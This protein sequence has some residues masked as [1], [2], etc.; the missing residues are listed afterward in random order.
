MDKMNKEKKIINL[1]MKKFRPI[2]ANAK[3]EGVDLNAILYT[4]ERLTPLQ[5][6]ITKELIYAFAELN[7]ECGKDMADELVNRVVTDV[8]MEMIL[9]EV[10]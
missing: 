10:I 9:N 4:G 7:K 6:E 5:V 8:A 3:A 1:A 2:K